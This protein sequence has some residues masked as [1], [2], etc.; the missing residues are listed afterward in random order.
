MLAHCQKG[1]TTDLTN[2][3][4]SWDPV[5]PQGWF[6]GPAACNKKGFQQDMF[7]ILPILLRSG[8]LFL[9]RSSYLGAVTS[10]TVSVLLRIIFFPLAP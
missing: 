5:G 8:S 7:H 3:W 6:S 9:L 10:A 2:S 4:S 1:L